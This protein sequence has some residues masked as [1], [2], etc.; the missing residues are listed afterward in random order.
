MT[1]PQRT[2]VFAACCAQAFL[3]DRAPV[4]LRGWMLLTQA[5]VPLYDGSPWVRSATQLRHGL[6]QGLLHGLSL[7]LPLLVAQW[8]DECASRGN[9]TL[10][11][12]SAPIMA[13]ALDY[14]NSTA[15]QWLVAVAVYIAMLAATGP[16]HEPFGAAHLL[17]LGSALAGVLLGTA[18]RRSPFG[19]AWSEMALVSA[20]MV[21]VG[22]SATLVAVDATEAALVI[23]YA[24]VSLMTH[25]LVRDLFRLFGFEPLKM[26]AFL[27]ARRAAT[28]ALEKWITA[29]PVAETAAAVSALIGS[30]SLSGRG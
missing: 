22:G 12:C 29:A 27:T 13:L 23:A 5:L 9:R 26:T 16:V 24:A 3:C 10:A 15:R 14:A 25:S 19:P 28:V 18:Q 7:A 1:S 6:A 21:A 17:L 11:R 4:R 2:L 8:C 20:A 30:W